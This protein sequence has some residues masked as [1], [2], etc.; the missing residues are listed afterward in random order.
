MNIYRSIASL[1]SDQDLEA[2]T[3]E[4][5]DMNGGEEDGIPSGRELIVDS[6]G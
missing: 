2:I 1:R 6:D 3:I 4:V 5:F